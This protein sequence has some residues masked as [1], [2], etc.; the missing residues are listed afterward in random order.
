MV[1]S[2]KASEKVCEE[3]ETTEAS[4][5]EAE[6]ELES[7]KEAVE[8]LEKDDSEK[9]GEALSQHISELAKAKLDAKKGALKLRQLLK[10]LDGLYQRRLQLVKSEVSGT[11]EDLDTV[12]QRL[13]S[14]SADA[15]EAQA[16]YADFQSRKAASLEDKDAAS[17]K[18]AADDEDESAS[19]DKRQKQC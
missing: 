1:L 4:L 6:K 16:D 7:N 8:R 10:K 17:K 9:T 15:T 11:K 19:G 14:V 13:R 3:L 2:K 5:K 12:M 18:R